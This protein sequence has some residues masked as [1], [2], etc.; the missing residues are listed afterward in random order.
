MNQESPQIFIKYKNH[1]E[2]NQ[3]LKKKKS[4]SES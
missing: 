3:L 4:Y 1:Y 2:N